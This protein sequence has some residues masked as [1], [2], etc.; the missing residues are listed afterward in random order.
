MFSGGK[1]IRGPHS[2]GI[3]TGRK[4][5]VAAARLNGPPRGGNIGHGTKVNKEEILGMYVALERYVNLDHDNEW[6]IWEERIELIEN[7]AGQVEG[8]RTKVTVPP[9]AN[10]TPI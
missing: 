10:H 9:I 4:D 3:L 5:L 2:A 6:K 8:V 7:T 1:A